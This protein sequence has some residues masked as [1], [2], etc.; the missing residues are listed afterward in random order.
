LSRFKIDV[1]YSTEVARATTVPTPT[2]R[3][4]TSTKSNKEEYV[5]ENDD[6]DDD[7]DDEEE[8]EGDTF[9]RD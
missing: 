8:N 5:I 9:N 4:A 7:D 1:N 6:E 2:V 3:P